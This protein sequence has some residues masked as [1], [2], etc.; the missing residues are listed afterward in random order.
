MSLIGVE[1]YINTAKEFGYTSFNDSS[2][3]GVSLILGGG[4]IYPIEHLQA[5]SVFANS[6]IKVVL[7]PI[8]KI[9]DSEGNIIYQSRREGQHIADHAASFLLNQTLMNLDTGV[10]ETIGFDDREI[11]GKTGTTQ[12]NK[13]S[14][15]IMYS[16][17][18]V[19]LGWAGN[20]NNEPMSQVF[21][22]PGFTVA[23]WLRGYMHEI[24]QT[25]SYISA[26]TP[27]P[28]PENVYLGDSSSCYSL[29]CR[30]VT[31]DWMIKGREPSY[32]IFSSGDIRQA[33]L[34]FSNQR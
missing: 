18:F 33:L 13:D 9:L 19:T 31:K 6:G 1:N 16:P 17:D 29:N 23:P 7:N 5:Y 25:S 3:F 34:A 11:A 24:S 27:F 4:D 21:G 2:N 8:Q 28:R 20:N 10:G 30:I 32:N 26:K 12:D 14:F 15:L 22:W